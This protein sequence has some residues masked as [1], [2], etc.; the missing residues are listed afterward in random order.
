MR[1]LTTLLLPLLL[2]LG[3]APG[4]VLSAP[5][6]EPAGQV[7]T[8][9]GEAWLRGR[10]QED[11]A[12][13]QQAILPGMALRTGRGGGVGVLL[14]DGTRIGLGP[15]SEFRLD[16]YRFDPS[17]GEFRLAGTLARGTLSLTSGSIGRLDSRGI[18]LNTP[19]G[20]VRVRD[21]QALLKVG[22]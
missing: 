9:R 4:E 5:L 21:A 17:R 19:D 16:E 14:G 18:R 11:S 6:P 2:A 10:G 8:L 22:P 3:M 20:Q 7:T 13:L 15:N 12:H 1:Y